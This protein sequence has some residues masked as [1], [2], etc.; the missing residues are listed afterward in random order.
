MGEIRAHYYTDGTK[1]RRKKHNGA[2]KKGNITK[3]KKRI[4]ENDYNDWQ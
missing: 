3:Q 4:Q 2:K 1:K